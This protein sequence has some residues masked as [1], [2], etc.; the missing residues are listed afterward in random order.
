MFGVRRGLSDRQVLADP[1]NEARPSR[2]HFSVAA[3]LAVTVLGFAIVLGPRKSDTA[4]AADPARSL[5]EGDLSLGDMEQI[6]ISRNISHR[7]LGESALLPSKREESSQVY[8]L[9]TLRK[10]HI[11]GAKD[12][13]LLLGERPS[14][15]SRIGD[16]YA[17]LTNSN[18][19]VFYTVD[20]DLQEFVSKLV[21]NSQAKHVAVVVMNP[22]T[23]AVLAIAGKSASIPD[24]EYH[25][26][27][28]A[29][30]LFKVVTAAAAVEQAGIQPSSLIQFRGGTYTLNEWN[31]LPD[32]KKDRNIMSVAEALG[33]SCNPVFGQLGMRYLNGNILQKYAR[34]FGFN[35]SLQLETP[36]LNSSAEIPKQDLYELSRTAAGFGQVKISPIHA[37][38]IMSGVANGGLLPRPHIVEEIVSRDGEI[39]SRTKPDVLNRVVQPSTAASLMEMMRHTTTIGTSRREFMRGSRPT[40]GTIEVAGK[41][42]TLRGDNPVGLN[43]WFI[44][45]APLNNPE[46][47]IAV[48][49]VDAP[50]SGKASRLGRKVFEKY[51]KVQP[52][53]DEPK[54]SR[55]SAKKKPQISRGKTSQARKKV[56]GKTATKKG[57]AATASSKK[58]KK[59]AKK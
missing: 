41:T 9:P 10:I 34:L 50:Y 28:P 37:A 30:S 22:R 23:G 2:A 35:R 54:Y 16:R 55:V 4:L 19:F 13:R 46:L 6:Q 27:F 15:A 36:L 53:L 25:A 49:T 48:I 47:S 20:P 57:V 5:K 17:S 1:P 42:G 58:S 39:L 12:G 3:T 59:P 11:E 18:N 56:V 43:N 52:L 45:S 14:F 26:D 51:F 40:L 32:P 33:R 29:A 8:P 44:G 38:A 31:Y 21:S 24:I 7:D